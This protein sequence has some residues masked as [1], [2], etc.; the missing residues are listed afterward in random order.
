[1]FSIRV[2]GGKAY[3]AKQK[4]REVKKLFFRSK[5]LHKVTSTKC[6]D[7]IKLICKAAE[8]MNSVNLQKYDY[9]PNAI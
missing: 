8:N 5:R 3:A 2:C 6:F 9:A 4:I 7:S 1:M